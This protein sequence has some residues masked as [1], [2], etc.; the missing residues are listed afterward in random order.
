MFR[1]FEA[2]ADYVS[3]DR[4]R[5][6]SD[7]PDVPMGLDTQSYKDDIRNA[8]RDG[9]I[10]RRQGKRLASTIGRA[11]GEMIQAWAEGKDIEIWLWK[12][13]VANGC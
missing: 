8:I 4:D 12:V 6:R 3:K 11:Q 5:S 2:M 13:Q 7:D 1:S 10:S 9:K